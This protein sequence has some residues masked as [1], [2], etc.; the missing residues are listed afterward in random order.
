MLLTFRPERP[1]RWHWLTLVGPDAEDF[2]HR[3]TTAHVRALPKGAGTPACILTA[4][5]RFR[6]FFHLWRL[7]DGEYGFE[8]DGG[9]DDQALREFL[10]AIDQYTFAEK[11]TLSEPAGT[12]GLWIFPTEPLPGPLGTLHPGESLEWDS[13]LRACHH[14]DADFGRSWISLWGSAPAIEAWKAQAGPTQEATWEWLELERIR[15]AR[16]KVDA[17]ITAELNP[18]ELGLKHSIADN[19]GCYPGQEVIEKIIALGSP[20]KRLA[21]I[22]GQGARPAPGSRILNLADPAAEVGTIT[23]V[24]PTEGGFLALGVL[25]KVHAKEGLAVRFENG[26][27][28]TIGR[29]AGGGAT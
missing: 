22:D 16:P 12:E 17:E 6:S 1:T 13:G 14:G 20:A 26:A 15:H 23:S 7:R 18:L 4:Q 21:R 27:Q 3:I 2:L 25:R 9:T 19:K 11:I 29:L 28:G 5:G 10:A 8:L 24:R